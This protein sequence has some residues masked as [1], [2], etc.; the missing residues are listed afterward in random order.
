MKSHVKRAVVGVSLCLL[1]AALILAACIGRGKA[2]AQ[3]LKK[4]SLKGPNK[5]CVECHEAETPAIVAQWKGSSHAEKGIACYDCHKAEASDPDAWK[6]EGN[7]ISALVTPNDCGRCHAEVAKEFQASHHASAGKILGSLDNILGEI[8]EGTPVANA[9]CQ[10]CH[11]SKIAFKKDK[12]GKTLKDDDGKPI[13]DDATWPNS[14]IGRLNPD[15]SNGSCAACHSRHTFS[16]EMARRPDNCGKCHLGPDHPQKEIYEESKHGIAFDTAESKGKMHMDEKEW[17][18]GKTYHDAPTCAT[19]HMSATENQ[20][21]THDPGKR[22]SWTLRPKV[23]KKLENW[24]ERR[25]NMKEVC[26]NCHGSTWVDG[27]YAQYDR[28]VDLYN[29]KFAK[30]AVRIMKALSD[31]GLLT[32][33]PFDE[34][35]DWT[36]FFLWHHEGRRA[37]MGAAMMG[38]DYTQWHGMYEVAERFYMELVPQARE[39]A[40]GNKKVLKIIDE[41]MDMPQHQWKKG[42]SDKDKKKVRD[43]YRKRYGQ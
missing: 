2:N 29:E 26:L 14:G 6:H 40:H 15:G 7:V 17:I 12:S 28:V 13:I 25:K 37:R 32:A 43:F 33:T 5:E 39:A 10:Q 4:S 22:I 36:F 3:K 11:G 31:A 38:P 1:A 41:V 16:L 34:E 9:G 18:V 19:C 21:A 23:S 8:V 42:L 27:H 24:E 35:L 30:P 20:K